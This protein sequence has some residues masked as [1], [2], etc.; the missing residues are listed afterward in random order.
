MQRTRRI[1][2]EARIRVVGIG[3]GGRTAVN[4]LIA[5]GAYGENF[6]RLGR[7]KAKYDPDNVFRL[8]QNIE[9]TT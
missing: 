1:H 8:N 7:L 6:R 5:A 3:S 9:P 2:Q 4:R